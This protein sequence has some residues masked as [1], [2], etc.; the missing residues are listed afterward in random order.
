LVL[1]GN[2]LDLYINSMLIQAISPY[3]IDKAG[4]CI[5]A[6]LI[7]L[8]TLVGC[9]D[10]SGIATKAVM[11]SPHEI[12]ERTLV[13]VQP[14]DLTAGWWQQWQDP[15]LNQLIQ[16]SLDHNPTVKMARS[17]VDLANSLVELQGSRRFPSVS[18]GTNFSRVQYSETWYFPPPIGGGV[19]WD[20]LASLNLAFDL[21]IWGKQ[22]SLMGASIN[23]RQ[24]AE[25][26]AAWV[27]LSLVTAVVQAYAQ[28][29]L[30]WQLL[31]IANDD[32][33]RIQQNL[34]LDRRK[35]QAGLVAGQEIG[36]LDAALERQ[37]SRVESL[38]TSVKLA[39]S[40]LAALAGLGDNAAR[41]IG[42]P[43]LRD[44]TSINLPE[45][46]DAEVV[47]HR[48]DVEAQRWRIEAQGKRVD[49]AKADFLPN[50]N[51]L[52]F[53]GFQG[54]GFTQLFSSQSGTFGIGPA[55][56]LPIFD[57]GL[58]RG[59]LGA[60]TAVQDE[61]VEAYN[62]TLVR[63]LQEIS[64]DVLLL[65]SNQQELSY[66]NNALNVLT[67]RYD[68]I[69][70]GWRGGVTSFQQVLNAR[71]LRNEAREALVRKAAYRRHAYASLMKDVAGSFDA[72]HAEHGPAESTP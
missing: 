52:G 18:A 36:L 9:A 51:L 32:L 29:D 6:M 71:G 69:N 24:A 34:D 7:A 47:G 19:Y 66:A 14:A 62:Q 64:D 30:Q 56:S 44:A 27:R 59:K 4:V 61:I 31:D 53:I 26:E 54:F 22:R 46:I 43:Q 17:R 49:A 16:Q 28:L 60:E 21:D 67:A 58:R 15:Q 33:Q 20:N 11:L 40:Q 70:R 35:L 63:A 12:E 38:E 50:V 5:L 45:R 41:Q 2:Y 55:V 3:R 57:G 37:K 48:P 72:D 42:R 23:E 13:Q 1:D 25:A 10:M 65:K 8:S 68:A 39:Q